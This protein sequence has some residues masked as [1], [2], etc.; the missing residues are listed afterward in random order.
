MLVTGALHV[1]TSGSE[2]FDIRRVPERAVV[3][4]PSQ[5]Q[6][7]GR[8]R[9]FTADLL[10]H[11]RIGEEEQEVA[12]LIVGELGANAVQH[13]RSEMTLLL[14]LGDDGLLQISMSDSG[15]HTTHPDSGLRPD[16]HGRGMTIVEQL[17]ERL[18]IHLNNRGCVVSA[19]VRVKPLPR[20]CKPSD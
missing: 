11:W 6:L 15:A 2:A 20:A 3:T 17:A 18:E 9:R 19:C 16:E 12:V 8:L 1:P 10:R 4:V 5:A 14:T 7:V 13:G